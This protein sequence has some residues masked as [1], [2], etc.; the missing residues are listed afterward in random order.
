[1]S[2]SSAR[3]MMEVTGCDHHTA[4]HYLMRHSGNLQEA[5]SSYMDDRTNAPAS[6]SSSRPGL[7]PQSYGAVDLDTGEKGVGA[8]EDQQRRRQEK[9]KRNR[10]LSAKRSPSPSS[11]DLDED[12]VPAKRILRQE[13]SR[14]VE[15]VPE[16]RRSRVKRSSEKLRDIVHFPRDLSFAGSLRE[17]MWSAESSEKWLIVFVASETSLASVEMNRR[18]WAQKDMLPLI[19]CNFL[20]LEFLLEEPEGAMFARQYGVLNAPDIS[21]LD[22]RTGERVSRREGHMDFQETFQ[23]LVEFM[24][25]NP[26]EAP[27]KKRSKHTSPPSPSYAIDLCG[28]PPPSPPS[29]SHTLN[30]SDFVADRSQRPDAVCVRLR[31]VNGTTTSWVLQPHT[32]TKAI[33]DFFQQTLPSDSDKS[34]FQVV[35]LGQHIAPLPVGPHDTVSSAQCHRHMLCHVWKDPE[36]MASETH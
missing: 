31:D 18:V 17:A 20:F 5:M 10:G 33:V 24:E 8:R 25:A 15:D 2:Q 23:F 36:E 14:L 34:S 6:S 28:T 12:G 3:H 9:G 29:S 16:R 27:Q 11:L 32:P 4:L 19:Q 1:M 7:T 13:V 21:I 35:R 22:P 30:L 26:F